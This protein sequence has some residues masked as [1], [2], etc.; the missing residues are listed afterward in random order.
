MSTVAFQAGVQETLALAKQA[1]D[2]MMAM[3]NPQQGQ[4]P[5]QPPEQMAQMPPQ[6]QPQQQMQRQPSQ[7]EMAMMQGQGMPPEMGGNG[8]MPPTQVMPPT[9]GGLQ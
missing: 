7:E 3:I 9:P 8:Q 2:A 6:G 1:A 5:G 4:Q